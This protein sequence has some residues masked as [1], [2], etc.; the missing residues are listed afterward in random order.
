MC[1]ERRLRGRQDIGPPGDLVMVAK[2]SVVPVT[3]R[4]AGES[5]PDPCTLCS[6]SVSQAGRICAWWGAGAGDPETSQPRRG[7]VQSMLFFF[8]FFHVAYG[9]S[10]ARG[11]IIAIAASLH[12][13][14][15]N[16]RS[17]PHLQPTPQLMA[18]LDP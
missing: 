9:G 11:Q 3:A 8:F 15:N 16:S 1:G 18:M 13:S 2:M 17:E 6:S 7:L 14:H 12:H 10:Q 4:E 5:R